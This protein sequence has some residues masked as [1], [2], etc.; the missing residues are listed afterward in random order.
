MLALL[1]EVRDPR[2]AFARV[3]LG[4][5]F[6]I[7]SELLDEVPPEVEVYQPPGPMTACAPARVRTLTD[8]GPEAL[9][10]AL[11]DLDEVIVFEHHHAAAVVALLPCNSTIVFHGTGGF[12]I[13]GSANVDPERTRL[14]TVS[15]HVRDHLPPAWRPYAHTI[16]NAVDSRRVA[17]PATGASRSLRTALGLRTEDRC[18]AYVGR[19][20]PEKN[21]EAFAASLQFLPPEH[22]VL[23]VGTASPAGDTARRLASLRDLGGP[24]VHCLPPRRYIGDVLRAADGV[25]C[26]SREEGFGLMA[27]EALAAGI[28]VVSTR[29]GVIAELEAAAGPL[30]IPLGVDPSPT[31]VAQALLAVAS[32]K[33]RPLVAR[34]V[35]V[36]STLFSEERMARAW[37]HHLTGGATPTLAGDRSTARPSGW[38]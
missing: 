27:A 9:A 16:W 30:T 34:G 12:A 5:P 20:A 24:R 7:D 28:P 2:I 17:P 14:V 11:A 8:G 15:D 36:V 32:G 10:A 22:H 3:V 35:E 1:R 38:Q 33:A 13:E 31:E 18:W 19:F 37:V 26:T 23:L 6:S 25:V 29:V 21:L 4:Y